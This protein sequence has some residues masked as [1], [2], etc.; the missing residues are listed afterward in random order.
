LLS[1]LC[2]AVGV[3]HIAAEIPA[4]LELTMEGEVFSVFWLL[5]AFVGGGLCGVLVMA[6]M[7]LSGGL[8][9]Q[10]TRAL[11]ADLRGLD[12]GGSTVV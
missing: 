7:S 11:Q 9:K 8:P 6:L 1:E 5:A 4:A 10:S 12:L 3:E 2:D